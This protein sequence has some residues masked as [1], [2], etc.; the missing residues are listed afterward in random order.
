MAKAL[1]PIQNKALRKV[2]GAYK[3][4]PIRSLE[5]EAYCPP[6]ELYFNKRLADFEARLQRT[7]MAEK[8]A[9]A[10]TRVA[11]KLRNCRGRR[12]RDYPTGGHWPWARLWVRAERADKEDMATT[13][14]LWDSKEAVIR[15]WDAR[16]GNETLNEDNSQSGPQTTAA[17]RVTAG[18]L[19]GAHLR[20]YDTLDK[21]HASVL[22]Q[23]RTGKIGLRKFLATMRVPSVP[24]PEC[25]CG[26]GTQD[27][28]HLFC[29]CLHPR[30][31]RLRAMGF[32]TPARVREGLSDPATA[33]AM[34][35][36]LT[37]S[38]W[39][40]EFRVFEELRIR[41]ERNEDTGGGRPPPH[42]DKQG[43]SRARPRRLGV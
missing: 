42:R 19:R 26:E 13:Q 37:R 11:A 18:T 32:P 10:S 43:S 22:C 9:A 30:S 33:P 34:A 35:K 14:R 20:L 28:E 23:A 8:L 41:K 17:G 21:A 38:G 6:L 15:D 5:I 2:L 36:A 27:V 31:S 25:P 1:A 12:R 29:E 4:T 7:G 24:S 3:A 16:L 40:Q 39:L